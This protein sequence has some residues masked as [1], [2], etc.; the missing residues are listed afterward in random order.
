MS[1]RFLR[2]LFI[3]RQRIRN[4]SI[5]REHVVSPQTTTLPDA[6]IAAIIDY[7]SWASTPEDEQV[8]IQEV[9]QYQTIE[10]T[11]RLPLRFE[12]LNDL[13]AAPIVA[14]DQEVE[15]KLRLGALAL[16]YCAHCLNPIL[17]GTSLKNLDNSLS[18]L[19]LGFRSE[20]LPD[21][22]MAHMI[23]L[24]MRSNSNF[25]DELHPFRPAT[26]STIWKLLLRLFPAPS[27]S[28]TDTFNP[29]QRMI[30]FHGALVMPWVWHNNTLCPE[31][32]LGWVKIITL[33]WIHQ[34]F[35]IHCPD[36]MKTQRSLSN[37][38]SIS[39]SS[40][41]ESLNPPGL[42]EALLG[43]HAIGFKVLLG[44]EHERNRRCTP[45]EYPFSCCIASILLGIYCELFGPTQLTLSSQ[46]QN[47]LRIE[48]HN[49]TRATLERSFQE[50]ANLE[51]LNLMLKIPEEA[52]VE[53]I[54]SLEIDVH[55]MLDN[56]LLEIEKSCDPNPQQ[57]ERLYHQVRASRIFK[58]LTKWVEVR[59]FG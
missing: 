36:F 11:I 7:V 54:R 41:P 12:S 25:H 40:S 23:C 30:F 20:T 26:N 53:L 49:I 28:S 3:L 32:E 19:M 56:S 33:L 16:L 43:N 59:P 21:S 45:L 52:Y 18:N 39:S 15:F 22:A 8:K 13:V 51:Q 14:G 55:R 38:I 58:F 6:V 50:S 17:S 46:E 44:M 9:R 4:I 24:Y 31:Q 10:L 35:L 47:D 57:E 27:L 29:S 42:V 37:R 1:E 48:V 2:A 34:E 5:R